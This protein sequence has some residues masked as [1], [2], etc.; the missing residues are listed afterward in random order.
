MWLNNFSQKYPLPFEIFQLH[1]FYFKTGGILTWT[2]AWIGMS[3]PIGGE[4][5]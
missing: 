4:L 2:A 1:F 3:F 5:S